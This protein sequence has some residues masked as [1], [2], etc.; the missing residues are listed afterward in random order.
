VPLYRARSVGA[1]PTDASRWDPERWKAR[2]PNSAFRAARLDDKFWAARRLLAF[3]DELLEAAVRVGAFNDPRSEDRL[4]A[5]LIGRRDA[6]V[7]RY[8]PAVSPIVD[9]EL[10]PS[11]TVTFRNAAVDAG[12]ATAPAEYTVVWRRFDNATGETSEL[13]TTK[14]AAPSLDAPGHLPASDGTYVQL[15]ISATGGPESWTAP[16]H[17]FF[18]R[19]QDRWQLVGFQRLPGGNP[20]AVT[21]ATGVGA[22]RN[23]R[24]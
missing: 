17:A 21:W 3:R 6:I 13:G 19:E 8:L 9:L 12:I 15:E 4:T 7:R 22:P 1:F 20:P 14:A 23:A 10:S 24:R 18:R 2:Y 16:A 5:F 11:G